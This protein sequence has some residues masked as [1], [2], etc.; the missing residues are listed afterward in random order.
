MSAVTVVDPTTEQEVA[1]YP[2]HGP[3]QIEAALTAADAAYRDWR[4]RPV[5][6]RAELLVAV[7]AV[8]RERAEELARL[9][10]SEMGKPLAEARFEIEKSASALEYFAEAG[11]AMLADTEVDAGAG[12]HVVTYEPIGV[13]FAVMPW[14]FPFWQVIRFAGPALL[15]GNAALLKHAPN[16]SGTA[17]ALEDAFTAAGAPAGLFTSLIVGSERVPEVSAQ[18]IADPRVAAVTLTGSERAGAFVAAEAGKALKKSVLELGGSDPFVVLADADLDL[19]VQHAVTGRLMTAGQTCIAPKRFLVDA[20]V[21]DTFQTKLVAALE[22]VK[23][24]DPTEDG[25]QLGPLARLDIL[26]NLERQVEATVAE[27]AEL[28]TGGQRLDRPGFFFAPTVLAGVKPGM[29]AFT[30]ET[31]GPVVAITPFETEDEAVEL[32][33]DT[34]YGLGATVWST[35]T[36][37]AETVARRIESGLVSVNALVASDPRLPFGGIKRSGYGR[38]LASVGMHEFTNIR[39]FKVAGV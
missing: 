33:N 8:L 34:R 10:V 13:I 20:S 30:E 2:E 25:T 14:N 5:A 19:A 23:I 17:L 6:E 1:T 18:L 35:D 26:E 15:A 22:A 38:E 3:E 31:F 39:T 12:R 4:R 9:V 24:G 29:T 32:A 7:A 27:G 11:P 28:K 37:R 16:V 36:E 21:V